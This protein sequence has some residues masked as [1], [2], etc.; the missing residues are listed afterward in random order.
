MPSLAFQRQALRSALASMSHAQRCVA[1]LFWEQELTAWQRSFL[2]RLPPQHRLW[3]DWLCSPAEQFGAAPGFSAIRQAH[4]LRQFDLLFASSSGFLFL[5]WAPRVLLARLLRPWRYR[6]QPWGQG[7]WWAPIG[8][9]L[10]DAPLSFFGSLLACQLL[11]Q[12]GIINAPVFLSLSAASPLMLGV[13]ER[14]VW[15]RRPSW[16]P[17]ILF[18]G[19]FG[20]PAAERAAIANLFESSLADWLPAGTLTRLTHASSFSE[21]SLDFFQRR[22]SICSA[23]LTA[24]RLVL[25]ELRSRGID[26]S[27]DAAHYA[28]T[29]L[30]APQLE[31][32]SLTP[33]SRS[34]SRSSTRL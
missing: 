26:P 34:G 4:R 2:S 28:L 29:T 8:W 7:F 17:S 24:E 12:L 5:P 27:V 18:Y 14:W 6:G 21:D 1:E 3:V 25:F 20:P 13:A 10:S 9:G 23:W 22:R 31:R 16:R 11:F 15:R 30:E 32:E 19:R 33:A